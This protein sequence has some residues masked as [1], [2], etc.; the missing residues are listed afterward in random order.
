MTNDYVTLNRGAFFATAAASGVDRRIL[1][2]QSERFDSA[3]A[4]RRKTNM[5]PTHS[6]SKQHPSCSDIVPRTVSYSIV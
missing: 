6:Q 1:T 2:K 4:A 3:A 5:R